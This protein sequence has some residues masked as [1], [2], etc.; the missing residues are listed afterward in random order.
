MIDI[1]SKDIKIDKVEKWKIYNMHYHALILLPIQ[2][3]DL[4]EL[5]LQYAIS[6]KIYKFLNFLFCK[7]QSNPGQ[8]RMKMWVLFVEQT[9]KFR[10]PPKAYLRKN[11]LIFVYISSIKSFQKEFCTNVF[12]ERTISILFFRI[13]YTGCQLYHSD[14]ITIS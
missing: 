11:G 9:L 6:Y 12:T 13:Q 3:V 4:H 14:S 7:F 2:K 1:A 5:D 8:F 10:R